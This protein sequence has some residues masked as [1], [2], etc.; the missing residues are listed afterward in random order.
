MI[1]LQNEGEFFTLLFKE[2]KMKLEVEGM[3]FQLKK[4]YFKAIKNIVY[5]IQEIMGKPMKL[6]IIAGNVILRK[7]KE[8]VKLETELKVYSE[9]NKLRYKLYATINND[10]EFF[11]ENVPDSDIISKESIARYL[12]IKKIEF[13][14]AVFELF[15]D[16]RISKT[17]H[18]VD[19]GKVDY[20]SKSYEHYD[21]ERIIIPGESEI[22]DFRGYVSQTLDGLLASIDLKKPIEDIC[23]KENCFIDSEYNEYPFAYYVGE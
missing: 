23:D 19:I 21:F 8:K 16:D 1:L 9:P 15:R 7:G 2:D 22:E 11:I 20:S 17:W 13:A 10:T 12:Y 3:K 18:W 6:E 5:G 4:K 14:C